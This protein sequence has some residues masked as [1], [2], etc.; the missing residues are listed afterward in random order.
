M[1]NAYIYSKDPLDSANDK[2]DYG[3]LKQ[4]FERN[5]I[6]EVVVDTLP[7]E[8]RAFV[9]IPGQGNAGKEDSINDELKN[10][11]RV[12]LFITG[13]EGNLFDIDKITHGNISIWVQC[14]TRKHQKYNK[15]PIGAPHHIKDNIPEYTEKTHTACFAGQITHKRRQ[16]LADIMPSIKDSIYKPTDGFAKGDEPKEYYKNLFSAKI[17]PAPAGAVSMD[18]FRFFEAI[19]MLC[20]PIA[21]LRNSKGHKDNFYHYIFDETL[22]FPSTSNWSE[23]PEIIKSILKDYPNNMHRVVSWWIKYKRDFAIKLMKEIYA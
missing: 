13:D 11:G 2:W 15:L 9:I 23:L 22:P 14:P 16:Q 19:E 21:D 17:A 1:T 18:S 8:E 20:L 12:V 10:I 6:K 7:Q 5:K 3:L 4:T